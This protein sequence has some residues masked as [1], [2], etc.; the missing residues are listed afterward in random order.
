M[1]T[2]EQ[3]C[4]EGIALREGWIT[5]YIERFVERVSW[6]RLGQI[7]SRRL[8]QGQ[9]DLALVRTDLR[10]SAHDQLNQPLPNWIAAI[11]DDFEEMRD[12]YLDLRNTVDP[13]YE[14]ERKALI[15][16]WNARWQDLIGADANCLPPSLHDV[17][18]HN[19]DLPG[20]NLTNA[21][22]QRDPNRSEH[23]N[24]RAVRFP[25][26]RLRN[27][28]FCKADLAGACLDNA[29]L[30]RAH[31]RG[32]SLVGATLRGA[33]LQGAD[34]RDTLLGEADFTGANLAH[35]RFE[36]ADLNHVI[37][38]EAN[39]A[40]ATGILFD[41]NSVRGTRFS[42]PPGIV[43]RLVFLLGRGFQWLMRRYIP[44]RE[45]LEPLPKP[46]L[47][48]QLRHAYTG[49][50]FFIALLFLVAFMMPYVAQAVLLAQI[51]RTEN[52]FVTA[53][54]VVTTKETDN[55][56]G[57][58]NQRGEPR[59][60]LRE[61][62]AFEQE[63]AATANAT[64]E[65]VRLSSRIADVASAAID[66][67]RASLIRAADAMA[68]L[69][70]RITA[71]REDVAKLA[72]DSMHD[73]RYPIWKILLG[74]DTGEL[75]WTLLISLLFVY[76]ALRWFLTTNVAPLRDAEERS[77]IT[78]AKAEYISFKPLHLAVQWLFW[79]S[80]GSGV[81]TFFGW[82]TMPVYKFW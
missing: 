9:S 70:A 48:T 18:F 45:R 75:G 17:N 15:E 67:L 60:L 6:D 58:P 1:Q 65:A 12:R 66:E 81:Y 72:P 79:L 63:L 24:H 35:A 10:K 82:M 52:A 22:L 62:V 5:S 71:L 40:S 59:R 2:K 73:R 3:R 8:E 29:D 25:G 16:K 77:S 69:E 74:I 44:S 13:E 51:G 36:G 50:N 26:A 34:L 30:T 46:D 32:A 49:A 68:T 42:K 37:F 4:A 41:A 27:V 38:D 47:W 23:A 76:N 21:D 20:I 43:E 7:F 53:V 33:K 64:R 54:G 28:N 11:F 61:I 57:L 19:C 39:L 78:P 14:S 80:F 31:L 56:A 55:A